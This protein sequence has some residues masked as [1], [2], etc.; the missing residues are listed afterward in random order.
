M[1]E[2]VRLLHLH[3]SPYRCGAKAVLM[4]WL[5]RID[6]EQVMF[7]IVINDDQER[8]A[9]E[10][11]AVE[12]GCNI[13][14]APRFKVWNALSYALWWYRGL[15][16]HPEWQIVH[17]HHTLPAFIYLPIA[18]ALGRVTIAHSHTAGG[19]RSLDG[20]VRVVLRWPLRFVAQV[21][22]ACSR[23]AGS[24]MFGR[25]VVAR[26]VN[27]G[28]ELE[29]F[30][31]DPISRNRVRQEFGL[32]SALVV[33]HVGSFSHPKN[34]SRLLRIFAEV[35][36]G[37]PA[38]RLLLV[39]DGG[40]RPQI[41]ADITSLGLEDHVV[42]AGVREDVPALL[43]AM[44]VLLF[45]SRYEGLPVTV[46][47]AQASGLPCVVSDAVTDEI[48]LTDLVRF[49]S[50]NELDEVWSK[51]VLDASQAGERKSKIKEL[52]DAGYDSAQV[53]QQLQDLYLELDAVRP[54]RKS[55]RR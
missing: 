34:H 38:A 3:A 7:D 41:E 31:F 26:V 13:I 2:Q 16:R 23:L 50:L 11:E 12:L 24:W 14:R 18:R 20:C 29:R 55:K 43:S 17:A 32:T 39:G 44:D 47:E 28:I 36:V 33:G 45:P 6:R 21:H 19:D 15:S 46:V 49:L 9:F 40:L 22:L 1:T 54:A 48:A 25:R 5:R 42:L 37:D 10:G 27:N 51:T 30:S 35:V 52:R 53:A 4:D 8:Y